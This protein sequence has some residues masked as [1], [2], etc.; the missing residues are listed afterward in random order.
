MWKIATSVGTELCGCWVGAL[1]PSWANE[2]LTCG[3]IM[4]LVPSYGLS[5]CINHRFRILIIVPLMYE[6]G[7]VCVPNPQ[8][9]CSEEHQ[10]GASAPTTQHPH[11]RPYES[12]VAQA[13]SIYT[14][15]SPNISRNNF[16]V[17]SSL[18]PKM[19]ATAVGRLASPLTSHKRPRLRKA[20]PPL[21]VSL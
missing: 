19:V 5:L 11:P 14:Y 10:D 12:W 2:W 17:S 15:S 8:R 7:S 3:W 16:S 1:A 4:T 6:W 21:W 20:M 18:A 13:S 9:I